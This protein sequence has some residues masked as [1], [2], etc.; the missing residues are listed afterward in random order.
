[1]AKT[2]QIPSLFNSYLTMC[3]LKAAS[4][5]KINALCDVDKY[6]FH[7]LVFDLIYFYLPRYRTVD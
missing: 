5:V 4:W 3:E 7:G 1:M 6:I 2:T